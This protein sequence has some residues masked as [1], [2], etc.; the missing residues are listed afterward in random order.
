MSDFVLCLVKM[1]LVTA[2]RLIKNLY[3][4]T[5]F[6]YSSGEDY[7]FNFYLNYICYIRYTSNLKKS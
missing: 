1:L 2:K 7:P 5:T 3:S 4:V 6:N